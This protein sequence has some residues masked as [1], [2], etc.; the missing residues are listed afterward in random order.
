MAPLTR[1]K[2]SPNI[3]SGKRGKFVVSPGG[4][5]T[6]TKE[7]NNGREKTAPNGAFEK[8][9]EIHWR[10]DN[11]SKRSEAGFGRGMR[12][13]R[14]GRA[15]H[16]FGPRSHNRESEGAGR[17]DQGPR[18]VAGED[19]HRLQASRSEQGRLII[20]RQR[21]TEPQIPMRTGGRGS[22]HLSVAI[23]GD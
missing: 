6:T 20:R 8:C 2:V 3:Q 17:I 18:K 15:R 10:R 11:R 9:G 13:P 14:K 16:P 23:C 19:Y 5:P 21:F 22:F 7:R 12:C 4:N 1:Y